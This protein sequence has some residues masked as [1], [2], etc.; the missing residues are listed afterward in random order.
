MK[1]FILLFGCKDQK[2]IVARISDFIL[3]HD[4]NIIT[5][6][7]YS[8]DPEG[9]HFFIRV[10][11][12]LGQD[13]YKKNDL[14][15][16]FSPIGSQFGA[17]WNFYDK[18]ET[19]RMGIC[20]SEPDHCL[21]DLLYLWS[22]GELNVEIPF[23]LSNV[24]K[25]RKLAASYNVPFHYICA[26]KNNRKEDELLSYALNSTDFLVLARYMLVLSP[27]FLQKYNK[28]IINIHHGF[29][30]FFKGADP[31]A[32]ALEE[33]VKVIGST[34]HFVNNELD[35]GPIIAQ[36]V[37]NVSH[38]DS[39]EDLVRKGKNLE[40]KALASAIA[41]YIDYRVIRYENKTI[42]F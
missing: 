19:L 13:Q 42:V 2:G 41:S 21:V 25:H 34:A 38:K 28:D 22:S 5:A 8:T 4:G 15:L 7:Q 9:G 18:S 39:R 27:D 17:S 10:E 36:E 1:T 40:K 37:Q 29:L 32:K 24:E 35:E 6:D 3:K 31:A 20:V 23:V 12:V 14:T 16:E 30:P 26:D 33:G 11:F